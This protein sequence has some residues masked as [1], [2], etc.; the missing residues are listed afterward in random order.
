MKNFLQESIRQH[1]SKFTPSDRKIAEYLLRSYPGCLLENASQIS[2][3]LGVTVSTVTRFFPK[4]GYGSI[5]EVQ[6]KCKENFDFIANSP[7][8]RYDNRMKND[9]LNSKLF[10]KVLNIDLLN[11]RMTFNHLKD[12]DIQ[13]FIDL[14]ENE[15]R[16][17]YVMGE[18]KTFALAF[19]FYIQFSAL[20]PNVFLISSEKSM[21]GDLLVDIHTDDIFIVFDF[22]RYPKINT[23]TAQ[24]FNEAKANIVIFTDSPISPIARIATLVFIIGTRGVSIFDS[25]TAGFTLINA[26]MAEIIEH[27]GDQIKERY[28]E[29]EMIYKH[30]EIFAKG[31]DIRK[32]MKDIGK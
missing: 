22:R 12:K 27:A 4:I 30:F 21:I 32:P 1:S 23:K 18:R 24:I 26:L 15:S 2:Q 5:H 3:K 25:Y 20:R 7:L 17:V 9:L 29:L 6:R 31:K 13:Y 14:V 8:D 11:L 28:E 10:Q 16:R 19:Y